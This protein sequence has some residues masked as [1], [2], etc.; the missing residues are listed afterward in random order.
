MV[1]IPGGLFCDYSEPECKSVEIKAFWIAEKEVTVKQ[2]LECVQSGICPSLPSAINAINPLQAI[3]GAS[4]L[5]AQKFLK[6]LKMSTGINARLPTDDEWKYAAYANR[7]TRFPWGEIPL[8]GKSRC[9]ESGDNK[10]FTKTPAF[11][12]EV[13]TYAPNAFGLYDVVGNVAEITRANTLRGGSWVMDCNMASIDYAESIR[14]K[15]ARRV[16]AGFRVAMN[17]V[18]PRPDRQKKKEYYCID[19][20]LVVGNITYQPYSHYEFCFSTKMLDDY[21]KKNGL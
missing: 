12:G 4:Y 17:K 7:E 19:K 10:R 11:S 15:S 14:S 18:V 1:E 3:S 9:L 2:W 16:T 13:G 6:W 21:I 20:S 5:D 8:P